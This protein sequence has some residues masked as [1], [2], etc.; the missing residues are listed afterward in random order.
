MRKLVTVLLLLALLPV[1]AGDVHSEEDA[2]CPVLHTALALGA[3]TCEATYYNWF[4]VR[5]SLKREHAYLQGVTV[6][7]GH[8]FGKTDKAASR[9]SVETASVPFKEDG[10]AVVV[11]SAVALEDGSLKGEPREAFVP[12]TDSPAMDAF[13][14]SVCDAVKT[15]IVGCPGAQI[16]LWLR[17][18]DPTGQYIA[19]WVIEP[20]RSPLFTVKDAVGGMMLAQKLGVD[21]TDKDIY[22]SVSMLTRGLLQ[23][24]PANEW[25][26]KRLNELGYEG[27]TIPEVAES[28]FKRD[29]QL[30]VGVAA[31][32]MAENGRTDALKAYAVDQNRNA[33]SRKL[34]LAHLLKGLGWPRSQEMLESTL[35]TSYTTFGEVWILH[36]NQSASDTDKIAYLRKIMDI[37]LKQDIRSVQVKGIRGTALRHIMHSGRPEAVDHLLYFLEN[38]PMWD[39]VSQSATNLASRG[40]ARALPIL[41]KLARESKSESN[42]KWFESKVKELKKKLGM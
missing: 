38:D 8:K 23:E 19:S 22:S 17:S 14:Q 40:E 31:M 26:R 1:T 35:G 18:G 30:T 10:T 28:V 12:P 5:L 20:G 4:A 37:G 36:V 27:Y 7:T 25:C 33:H 13:A 39:I 24:A 42:R 41:E 6:L 2:L 34:V 16:A 3:V 9:L 11:L 21:L 29:D 32:I 15:S